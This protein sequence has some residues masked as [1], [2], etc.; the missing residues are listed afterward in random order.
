MSTDP[1]AAPECTCVRMCDEPDGCC[2]CCG[3]CGQDVGC[4]G[5]CWDCRGTGHPH[6]LDDPECPEHRLADPPAPASEPD[7]RTVWCNTCKGPH[8]VVEEG[9]EGD[10]DGWEWWVVR[11]DCGHEEAT[12]TT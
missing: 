6:P 1:T 9:P 7:A 5:M 11:L 3:G 8:D 4:Q 12:R 10:P 2:S